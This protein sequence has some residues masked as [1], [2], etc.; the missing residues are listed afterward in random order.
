MK[1]RNNNDGAR[2]NFMAR[3]SCSEK[4]D[5]SKVSA[6]STR[7]ARPP[8]IRSSHTTNRKRVSF[9][10]ILVA[11]QAGYWYVTV[12]PQDRLN[13]LLTHFAVCAAGLAV[14]GVR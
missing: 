13:P 8:S 12:Q 14:C 5:K 11:P 9:S 10:A 3:H 4:K 6:S 7:L 1:N 2:A